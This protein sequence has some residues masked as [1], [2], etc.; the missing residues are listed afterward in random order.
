MKCHFCQKMHYEVYVKINKLNGFK[1]MDF[2]IL[3]FSFFPKL[4]LGTCDKKITIV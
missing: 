3:K 1:I 2:L 4:Y